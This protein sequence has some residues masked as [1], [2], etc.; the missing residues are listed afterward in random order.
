MLFA[1]SARR[2]S[3]IA[4]SSC[5]AIAAAGIGVAAAM[6]LGGAAGAAADDGSPAAARSGASGTS[7]PQ[8]MPGVVVPDQE[9]PAAAPGVS[10][11]KES[12][13]RE[14]IRARWEAAIKGDFATAYSFEAPAYREKVSLDDYSFR[15]ARKQ[16]SWH[17]ATL[18]ELRYDQPD[19]A[20]AVISLEYSFALPGS[21]QIVR[22]E[23]DIGEYWTRIGDEW[24]RQEDP[25][26]L[27][28]A[29][30]TNPSPTPQ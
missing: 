12:E 1:A 23:G 28:T 2:M 29:L 6:L 15:M 14:R 3:T 19:K 5:S 13:L 30:P 7:G 9:R 4:R 20:E 27:G 24:W 17:M 25:R 26:T 16:V 18:K 21:D 8:H 22:T 11:I 10:L